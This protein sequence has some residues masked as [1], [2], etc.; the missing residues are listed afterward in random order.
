MIKFQID[1]LIEEHRQLTTILGTLRRAP[2]SDLDGLLDKLEQTL[3][4]HT[5]REETGLFL[6]SSERSRSPR[7]IS[8]SSSM[9]M[10][11]LS[12]SSPRRSAIRTA[13]KISSSASRRTWLARRT[14][15]S[16][17]RNNCSDQPT[18]TTS[19]WRSH[20][21]GNTRRRVSNDNEWIPDGVC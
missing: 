14:T 15:C 3:A 2:G 11:T 1:G 17:L 6:V 12:T 18:G 16:R 10:G 8:P 19:R 4:H 13:W 7:T 9:T 21:C 20:T 5:E